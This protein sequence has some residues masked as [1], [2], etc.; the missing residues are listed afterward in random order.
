MLQQCCVATDI[1]AL[2]LTNEDLRDP[3]NLVLSFLQARKRNEDPTGDV[4]VPAVREGNKTAASCQQFCIWQCVVEYMP[5]DFLPAEAKEFES[6]CLVFCANYGV[7][8]ITEQPGGSYYFKYP[9]IA[10]SW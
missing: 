6:D 7:F 5:E 10:V 4:S 8:T 9:A 1:L 2:S 3:W